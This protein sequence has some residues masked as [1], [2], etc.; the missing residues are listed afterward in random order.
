MKAFYRIKRDG[1]GLW[2]KMY[3]DCKWPW[4]AACLQLHKDN[5]IKGQVKEAFAEFVAELP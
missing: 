5:T 3:T 2:L 1:Q 4:Y